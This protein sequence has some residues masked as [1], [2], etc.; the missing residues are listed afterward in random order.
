MAE[1]IYVLCALLSAACAVLLLRQHRRSAT[2][3]TF[4]SG[5]GFAG[6]AVSNALL[7]ADMMIFPSMDMALW[8]SGVAL[9]AVMAILYG[10]IWEAH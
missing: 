3:L 10:F 2:R 1:T 8:R 7:V 9:V 5:V 4:W 6:L